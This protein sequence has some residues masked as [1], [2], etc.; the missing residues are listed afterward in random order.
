VD[1]VHLTRQ[2]EENI[3]RVERAAYR[4]SSSEGSALIVLG[5]EFLDGDREIAIALESTAGN[6][7]FGFEFSLA[8]IDLTLVFST[9]GPKHVTV[10][11]DL[12]SIPFSSD[13]FV[14]VLS[15]FRCIAADS[16]S[17]VRRAARQSSSAT[18]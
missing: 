2:V 1:I 17:I 9:P 8:E 4:L 7:E 13:P 6:G 14:R 12:A 11:L 10:A 5:F 16:T 18:S 15:S 3:E